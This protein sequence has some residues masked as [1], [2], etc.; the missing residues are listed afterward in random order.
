M[1]C[2]DASAS[3][4]LPTPPQPTSP[5]TTPSVYNRTSVVLSLADVLGGDIPATGWDPSQPV[6][7]GKKWHTVVF[8]NYMT[9]LA[10]VARVVPFVFKGPCA[11]KRAVFLYGEDSAAHLHDAVA[12]LKLGEAFGGAK[13]VFRKPRLPVPYGTHHTKAVFAFTHHPDA[14]GSDG[15]VSC[16]D[17]GSG[18]DPDGVRVAVLTSN[19]ICDDLQRKN[20]GIYVQDFPR[21]HPAAAAATTRAPPAPTGASH[22]TMEADLAAYAEAVYPPLAA[23]VKGYDYTGAA[24]RLVASTPGYHN[25]AALRQWGLNRLE[26]V[27][28]RDAPMRQPAAATAAAVATASRAVLSLQYS[29]QGSLTD[30]FLDS[31]TAA[32]LDGTPAVWRPPS[33]STTAAP[34]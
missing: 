16:E 20:Q 31:F 4:P 3:V 8:S 6:T 28:R 24:V 33:S 26:A 27:L 23:W 29:S 2:N 12:Q 14:T 13:L 25:G 30:K 17:V 21:K 22:N 1:W 9:D 18:D 10:Y 11:A 34:S 15:D 7:R 5:R 19:F 32:M